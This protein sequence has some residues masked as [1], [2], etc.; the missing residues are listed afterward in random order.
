MP[1]Q[2]TYPGVYIEEIS[3]GVRTIAGVA[4]STAAFIGYFRRGPM[5]RAVQL[6]NMGDFEREFGGLDARS[7]AGYAIQQFF[8]NGGAQAY[9]VRVASGNPRASNVTMSNESPAAGAVMRIR[10]IHEGAWGDRIRVRIDHDVPVAGEFNMR[11]TE[12]SPEGT[13]LRQEVFLNLSMNNALNNFV[14][15]VVNDANTGSALI[16]IDATSGVGAPAANGTLSGAHAD[17]AS[18]TLTEASPAVQVFIDGNSEGNA[19]LQIA[20][21]T[22]SLDELAV[23]LENALRSMDPTNPLLAG[24]TVQVVD[25]QLVVLAGR[26][27]PETRISFDDAGADTTAT[28]L[29]LDPASSTV[30]LQYY[31]FGHGAY[32]NTAQMDNQVAA[33][34]ESGDNGTLPDA[35]ALRGLQ[36]NKT[37][38][39]ALDDVDLFNILCIP[40]T[41]ASA[42]TDYDAVF[43]E[44]IAYCEQ[45]RAFFI[46][47]TPE[48][49][50]T[51][52]EVRTWRAGKG[53]LIRSRNAALYFP[54]VRIPDP[55][56]GFR[57]RSIGACG[58]VAGLYARTDSARG[59][60]K[61]PA[62]T[63]ATLRNVSQLTYN[64]TDQQ[65]G[66]LN[67]LGINCLRNLPVYGN[68]CWGART[69]DGADALASEWKY[70]PVRRL[71]LFLEESLFRGTHWVVFEP[72]DEPLWAQIRLN[73]GAFMNNLFRQGAFQGTNPRDAYLVKCDRETTTQND[74]N[75]GIV[76]IV[77]GFAPLKPAEFVFIKIQQLAGQI[78][79]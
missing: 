57:L 54:R 25:D 6:F 55:L 56:N 52:Q 41:G 31:V 58:T 63:E 48:G 4:T 67:P 16:A 71:A 27:A 53:S 1:V 32:A 30:N 33:G 23:Y 35:A 43:S 46:I 10:A 14:T 34:T 7:E 11:V 44:A 18:V 9:A 22:Y 5:N 21:A 20:P 75:Q 3:S 79:S 72:N 24:A 26:G 36:S 39:Y 66:V 62:G 70:V 69:T 13:P 59:V 29:L 47:D 61:A 64:L 65:N 37:G 42:G 76:N 2:P 12:F 60:W 15:T 17:P 19:A 49:I 38:L 8:L 74:I 73:V 28:E 77:V 78:Q 68:I 40:R 50:D 45:K 51:L